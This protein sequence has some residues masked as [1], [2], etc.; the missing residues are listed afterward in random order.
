MKNRKN[1]IGNPRFLE[2]INRFLKIMELEA[3]RR[4]AAVFRAE[5][6]TKGNP[7]HILVF[8]MLSAR[9]KDEMTLKALE[10]IFNHADSPQRIATLPTKK[11]EMLINDVGFF[12]VKAIHLKALSEMVVKRGSVPDTLEGLLKLPGVG[13]KTA[14]IVLARAFGKPTLGVDT[15]VHKI[16]NRLGLANTKKP[17]ETEKALVRIVPQNLRG[18]LNLVFVGYGQTVCLPRRPLCEECTIR[19]I[20]PKIEV[21]DHQGQKPK[22][23]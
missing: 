17:E 19:G 22:I 12:H 15:H 9:T 3:R 4:N 8:T 14:N 2:E 6:A 21:V 10:R 16:S 18:K 23:S 1:P 20:C 5:E 7:F 13:R 11:I